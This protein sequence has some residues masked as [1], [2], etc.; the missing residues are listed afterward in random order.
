[1]QS[2]MHPIASACSSSPCTRQG[3]APA[4]INPR[5][6]THLGTL[7]AGLLLLLQ[8]AAADATARSPGLLHQLHPLVSPAATTTASSC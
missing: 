8:P 6:G 1:M 7:P 5:A 4:N 3:Q 2:G